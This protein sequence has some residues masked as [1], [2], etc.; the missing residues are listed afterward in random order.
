MT[1]R[2]VLPAALLAVF[3]GL[4]VSG[5]AG[6]SV[7]TDEVQYLPAGYTYLQTGDLRLRAGHPPFAMALAALPLLA[8][9][10]RPAWE[11]PSWREGKIWGFGGD[12]L[13]ENRAFLREIFLLGRLPIVTLGV[14]TG[15][16][17]FAW[18]RDLWGD[19]PALFVLFLFAFSP[20]LLAHSGLVTTDTGATCF[21]VATLYALWRFCGSGR[22]AAAGFC[23]LALGLGL[24]TKYSVSIT[25]L[26]AGVLLL[27]HVFYG[28][29]GTMSSAD[30]AA[31]RR[32]RARP[33]LATVVAGALAIGVVA[34]LVLNVGFG[35]PKGI[36]DYAHAF[37]F[38][39]GF[40]RDYT[41]FL[42]GEYAPGGFW[43]Y[44]LLAQLWKTP[45]PALLFFAAAL[46][47]GDARDR[48]DR[49]NWLFL[50]LPIVAFHVAASLYGVNVGFRYLLPALPFLFLSC[51]A[52]ARRVAGAGRVWK[53]VF[54]LVCVW[55][56]AG[57]LCVFP[58]F[59]AYFNELAGGP[60][61][62]IR[63]LGDSNLEWGQDLYGLKRYLDSAR[64]AR[65]AV[66]VTSKLDLAFYGI[67]GEP[68]GLRDVV[69]PRDDTT[70]VVGAQLLQRPAYR[71]GLRF[72]WLD[73]YDA[74][75]EIG[76]SI[77]VYRFSTDPAAR[78][79]RD[80][81]YVPR[82]RWYRDAQRQLA[83][84]LAQAP[85][86]G[87]ARELLARLH[88]ERSVWRLQGRRREPALADAIRALR[89]D[90][91]VAEYRRHFREV[92]A[93][94]QGEAAGGEGAPGERCTIGLA[95]ARADDPVR[96]LPDLLACLR[97]RPD[98]VPARSAVAE[99]YRRL[100]FP[101]LA[102]REWMHCLAADA[103]YAPARRGL[104]RLAGAPA[105]E[106]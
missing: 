41:S 5:M 75:D 7:T 62:G 58:H 80:V 64:P 70:Y 65:L 13:A 85:E 14:L 94:L 2:R 24:L 95:W 82:E 104:Q 74:V 23:G 100:A 26:V 83:Q 36:I 91:G 16:L 31:P 99:A 18:A 51:G 103:G 71:A 1:R 90:P 92:V 102:R 45:L 67:G 22:P 37:L 86:W 72:H 40:D 17:L 52:V 55:Y 56:A 34:A 48:T 77:Y 9:D 3:A 12:F 66:A 93:A 10:L 35:F 25:A 54:G 101:D 33:A 96:A 20:N 87:E 50:L 53:L 98:A 63:Y 106:G 29:T 27:A 68:M 88:F 42:W 105:G 19:R 43:Y 59:L 81:F 8:L 49:L 4:A 79:R 60:E 39:L 57:T 30:G 69:W 6:R 73:W 21:T 78:G 28:R 15:W 84:V 44:Y 89:G 11:S 61:N 32:P 97:R 38:R 46:V 76:W 47:L